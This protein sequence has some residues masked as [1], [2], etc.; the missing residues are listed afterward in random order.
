M[1]K[2]KV[3]QAIARKG[4]GSA[5][6]TEEYNLDD[7]TEKMREKVSTLCADMRCPDA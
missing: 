4:L 5:S 6:T 7:L 3:K 2:L 1:W